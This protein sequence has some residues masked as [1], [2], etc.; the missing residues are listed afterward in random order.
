MPSVPR[1]AFIALV[2]CG[3]PARQ[4]STAD[5]LS[6][7]NAFGTRP[8]PAI[9]VQCPKP[10][11]SPAPAAARSARTLMARPPAETTDRIAPA[12][13]ADSTGAGWGRGGGTT[14]AAA[15][16]DR[17][18][19]SCPGS[20][21]RQPSARYNRRISAQSSTLSTFRCFGKGSE[22]SRP[23]PWGQLSGGA[24]NLVG[25]APQRGAPHQ[26]VVTR[27]KG[28]ASPSVRDWPSDP[29]PRHR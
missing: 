23:E 2:S 28:T 1:K 5:W 14:A 4:C 11:P 16:P 7:I 25:L 24:D 6:H 9:S 8:H 21:D 19:P 17:R 3:R 12:H 22:F 18:T 26:M 20:V 27:E 15:A 13:R 29:R 10:S